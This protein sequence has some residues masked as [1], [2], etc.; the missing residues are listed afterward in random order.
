MIEMLILQLWGTPLHSYTAP[1]NYIYIIYTPTY[2]F[3][4]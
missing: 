4:Y 2:S 3:P 1:Y